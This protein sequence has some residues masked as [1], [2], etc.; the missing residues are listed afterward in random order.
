VPPRIGHLA[1]LEHHMVD[2]ALAQAAAGGEPCVPGPDDDGS[3]VF[4]G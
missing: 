1:A 3:D 4:D 2:P